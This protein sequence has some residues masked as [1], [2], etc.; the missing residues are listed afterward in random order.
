MAFTQWLLICLTCFSITATLLSI[1]DEDIKN[2]PQKINFITDTIED[3][4]YEKRFEKFL[5]GNWKSNTDPTIVLDIYINNNQISGFLT[6]PSIVK[7][8]LPDSPYKTLLIN[9]FRKSNELYIE[10]Y[11]FING[12][13][14]TLANLL[15]THIQNDMEISEKEFNDCLEVRVTN[16]KET[17]LPKRFHITK[18]K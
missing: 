14:T 10:I 11:E 6:S 15:I 1:K 9:G 8:I 18:S 5:S 2:I 7:K 3:Y 12:K 16:Q 17:F 13:R 4:L